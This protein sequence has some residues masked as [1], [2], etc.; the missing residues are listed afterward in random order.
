MSASTRRSL[1]NRVLPRTLAA[2]GLAAAIG[3][4]WW[5]RVEAARAPDDPPQVAM[6]EAV[7]LGRVSLTPLALTLLPD[8]DQAALTLHATAENITGETQS[9]LFGFPPHPPQI[10]VSGVELAEPEVILHRDGEALQQLQ[11]RLVERVSIT[12]QVP[13]DFRAD[14]LSL[15]FF[16]QSFKLRDNL[17]GKSSWLGFSPSARLDA[18]VEMRAGGGL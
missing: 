12:W 13:Q 15:T 9:G 7:D 2:A 3:V 8:G 14:N 6:G 11:P 16:R 1:L 18:T 10:E 17:Y 5:M 4:S